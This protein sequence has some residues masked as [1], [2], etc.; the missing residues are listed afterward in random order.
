MQHNR[1]TRSQL[2]T[3]EIASEESGDE[4][5][6]ELA[7]RL[8]KEDE[9]EETLFKVKKDKELMVRE[10]KGKY[11]AEDEDNQVYQWFR[12]RKC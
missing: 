12:E 6:A 10:R 8:K 4:G 11:T 9:L 5:Y 1:L 3:V 2:E 7:E